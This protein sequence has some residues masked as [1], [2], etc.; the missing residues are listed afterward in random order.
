MALNVFAL[1]PTEYILTSST[2]AVGG[3]VSVPQ[4]PIFQSIESL[5]GADFAAAVSI[6]SFIANKNS[7][8]LFEIAMKFHALSVK[9]EECR[10]KDPATLPYNPD[11][12]PLE[13][14][15]YRTRK[16]FR[17]FDCPTNIP[18]LEKVVGYTHAVTVT[19]AVALGRPVLGM[20]TCLA[21]VSVT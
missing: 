5:V 2:Y 10:V 18:Q 19:S 4:F 11:V 16:W 21:E 12:L 7:V 15:P 17:L 20:T 9:A 8:A 3:N 14:I 6:V 13:Y 1:C